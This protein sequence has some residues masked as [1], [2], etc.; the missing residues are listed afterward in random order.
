MKVVGP[1]WK[2]LPPESKK[3]F[4]QAY[5]AERDK[6]AA[7]FQR[8][9]DS[10]ALEAWKRDPHKPKLPMTGF[11]RFMAEFRKSSHVKDLKVTEI[12]KEGAKRWK[13]E[14][15]EKK[16]ALNDAYLIDKEKYTK[17]MEAYKASGKEIEWKKK[18]GIWEVEQK[19]LQK[20]ADE[21][22]QKRKL[23]EK[24]R[25]AAEKA[26]NALKSQKLKE[27]KLKE[28]ELLAT[29]KDTK[30]KAKTSSKEAK[31]EISKVGGRTI[32]TSAKSPIN[33]N[34]PVRNSMPAPESVAPPKK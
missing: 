28:K 27:K 29:K 3:P 4:I 22:E 30:A 6:Y 17:A 14:N 19:A 32:T 11:L 26:K 13:V 33:I 15:P 9:K 21:K 31:S 1:I 5:E 8:Y 24:A 18:V 10:G 25:N 7:A 2:G 20:K 23:A 16:K 34:P 12:V